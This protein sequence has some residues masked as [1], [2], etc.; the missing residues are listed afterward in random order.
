MEDTDWKLNQT[1][2]GQQEMDE[3]RRG[4]RLHEEKSFL[5]EE[6]LECLGQNSVLTTTIH[7]G[8]RVHRTLAQCRGM[9][10]L[11]AVCL[12]PVR[13][14]GTR[15]G[16]VSW[17][18]VADQCGTSPLTSLSNQ[19]PR[20]Q[21]WCLSFSS[22]RMHQQLQWVMPPKYILN[23]PVCNL[24][25]LPVIQA[26]LNSLLNGSNCFYSCCLLSISHAATGGIPR[27]GIAAS[28]GS[29]IY[30][31]WRNCCNVFHDSC[32]NLHFQQQYA[33]VYSQPCQQ[34]VS[35]TVLIITICQQ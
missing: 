8:V 28:N 30:S 29:S 10:S 26:I 12:E 14:A 31:F 22:Y 23:S 9:L 25:C 17:E 3:E 24:Q 4:S 15:C 20:H 5:N 32:I 33:K 2:K 1:L 35:Y 11:S 16:T 7:V 6:I 27:R 21:P 34:L 18:E 13:G 19:K